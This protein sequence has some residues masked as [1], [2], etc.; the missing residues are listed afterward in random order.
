[1]PRFHIGEI[2]QTVTSYRILELGNPG[3]LTRTIKAE[4]IDD[5]CRRYAADRWDVGASLTLPLFL[6]VHGAAYVV[7]V[8]PRGEIEKM[9]W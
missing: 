4:T 8:H 5:A 9:D 6:S 1:M 7:C 2:M 3:E